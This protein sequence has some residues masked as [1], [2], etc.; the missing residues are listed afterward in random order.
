VVT[1]YGG[2]EVSD[3]RKLKALEEE[4]RKLKKLLAE[5][6]LDVATLREALGK[7][8]LTPSSRRMVVTWAIDQKG[9]IGPMCIS[10][11]FTISPPMYLK[12][13]AT[14]LPIIGSAVKNEVRWIRGARK[15][16]GKATGRVTPCWL[17]LSGCCRRIA[18]LPLSLVI[19]K[20]ARR[21]ISCRERG[22]RP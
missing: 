9:Y 22:G 12:A 21:G 20:H 10:T 13:V 7:K 15:P 18:F 6:M 2:M 3:A 17:E 14:V 19:E 1:K 5:S 16:A 4:N 11:T 8:L